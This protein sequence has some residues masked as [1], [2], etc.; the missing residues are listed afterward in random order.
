MKG[1]MECGKKLGILEGY[2]HPVMGKE[3][4]LC[5]KCF[6]VVSESVERYR[7]FITPYIGFFHME[8]STFDD[9]RKIEENIVNKI[10]NLQNRICALSSH[11]T[12]QNASKDLTTAY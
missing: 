8:S 3:H 10:M 11:K 9:L 7:E 5:S 2:R 1:C 12:T 4:L 6:V